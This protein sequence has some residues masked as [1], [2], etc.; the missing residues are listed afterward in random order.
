MNCRP[1]ILVIE[2]APEL[3]QLVRIELIPSV[4]Q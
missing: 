4:A 2:D 1:R 3:R